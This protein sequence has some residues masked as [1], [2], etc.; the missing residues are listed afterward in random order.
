MVDGQR[1]YVGSINLSWTSLTKNREVGLVVGEPAN[2]ATMETTL[3][4]D[5]ATASA[6]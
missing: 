4:K 2:V 5:W 6:L 3:E 1:A